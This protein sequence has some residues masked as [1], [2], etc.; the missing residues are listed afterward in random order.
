MRPS[1]VSTSNGQKW[2]GPLAAAAIALPAIVALGGLAMAGEGFDWSA[3]AHPHI[4]R[5]IIF[6]GLQAFVSTVLSL[7][8]GAALALALARRR[9]FL[10]RHLFL[11]LLATTTVLPS[12]VVVFAI[13][14]IYGRSGV[15]NEAL[16]AIG[17]EGGSWLYGLPGILIAHVFLNMPFAARVYLHALDH[18]PAEHHRLAAELGMRP[19]AVFRHLDWPR[20]KGETPG[21]AALIFLLCF[22]SFAIVLALGGGPDRATLEVAIY[23]AL[24][25]EGDFARAALLAFVQIIIGLVLT[26]IVVTQQRRP[27]EDH[28][29]QQTI[30]R[31][32]QG[33][34]TLRRFDA[35]II[36]LA[37]LFLVPPLAS[38]L[39]GV[40]VLFTVL[41][42]DMAQALTTSLILA[43]CSA[44][45]TTALAYAMAR[46]A[47]HG[48]RAL[49][50]GIAYLALAMPPFAMVAGLYFVLR[51][52]ADM[53]TL[54][55]PLI[56]FINAL[57]ALPFAYRL[58]EAP[59]AIAEERHGKLALSLGMKAA[60]RFRLIEWPLLARPL[61]NAAAL[62]AA[63]SLGDFGVI[64]FFG[65]GDLI[66]LPL[67]LYQQLGAY[68][69]EE[70][71]GTALFLAIL[72]FFFALG[73]LK[74][75][76]DAAR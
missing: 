46:G 24:R 13:V 59:L 50:G 15:V 7:I 53:M 2:L 3:L 19:A 40:P 68:R 47:L 18:T 28:G 25:G 72:V 30:A 70:A 39:D 41:S 31:A 9:D 65:G 58:I 44:V 1:S 33:S 48:P 35:C 27:D 66:T 11:A 69:M 8:V 16:A 4:R 14:A 51:P 75:R 45:L 49:Y 64:A 61:K 73:A 17:I 26:L 34:L 60:S 71:A 56:V 12:I 42:A 23:D 36:A 37:I 29:L 76:D 10:G 55:P 62:A 74:D 20:L 38:L 63:L 32:D 21:L 67:M 43:A 5:V 57:M 52:L 6:S 22:I 54:G